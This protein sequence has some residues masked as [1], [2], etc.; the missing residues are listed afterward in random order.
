MFSTVHR[1]FNLD[2]LHEEP[3]V[4]GGLNPQNFLTPFPLN[5]KPLVATSNRKT[6][7]S[8]NLPLPIKISDDDYEIKLLEIES[9]FLI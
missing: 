1:K 6:L 9:K 5:L 2:K 8:Q 3:S 7:P 4:G